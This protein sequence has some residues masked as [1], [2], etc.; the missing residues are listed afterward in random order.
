MRAGTSRLHRQV[1]AHPQGWT[2]RRKEL[3][4]FDQRL[5]EAALRSAAAGRWARR[6]DRALFWRG[7]LAGAGKVKGETTPAYAILDPERIAL[8]RRRLP[9]V[10]L[11]HI[12][13]DPV[14]RAG[15][16]A[17]KDFLQFQDKALDQVSREALMAFSRSEGVLRRGDYLGC[18][19]RRLRFFP[20]EQML[21][22]FYEDIQAKPAQ[23]LPE[24]GRRFLEDPLHP[25]NA[26]VA[27]LLGR[28]L[29]WAG[30]RA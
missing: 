4:F 6:R 21:V 1:P 15:S 2:P 10:R 3:H 9:H 29:P 20:I 7:A 18:L 13:R 26:R 28:A 16:D 24:D 12:L 8:I 30:A 17:R 11:I 22:L 27:T 5:P 25:Q 19:E 23:P 14:D